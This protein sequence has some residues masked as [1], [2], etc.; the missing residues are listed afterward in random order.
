MVLLVLALVAAAGVTAYIVTRHHSASGV[1]TPANETPSTVQRAMLQ[2]GDLYA[3]QKS[4]LEPSQAR[5]VLG[6]DDAVTETDGG[7][8]CLPTLPHSRYGQYRHW[9]LQLVNGGIVGQAVVHIS[10]YATD[11]Q[12]QGAVDGRGS[13]AYLSCF[14][15]SQQTDLQAEAPGGVVQPAIISAQ[16]IEH[17]PER[18]SIALSTREDYTI[19]GRPC[20]YYDDERF[21]QVGDDVV[22]TSFQA[23]GAKFPPV[24]ERRLADT[25]ITR[26][27][28]VPEPSGATQGSTTTT[29]VPANQSPGPRPDVQAPIAIVGELRAY[30]PAHAAGHAWASS[31][32]SVIDDVG[33]IMVLVNSS[34]PAA[35]M[36]LC[37]VTAQE[38]YRDPTA[39][40]IAINVDEFDPKAT[41]A[42]PILA[43]RSGA[44]GT[45]HPGR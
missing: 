10:H 45:C 41:A 8:G 13:S 12:A 32:Q 11:A 38:M 37:N 15:R 23:C 16:T 36:D 34:D 9:G 31:Y 42:P 39:S 33:L 22:M 14:L 1:A 7:I 26:L 35:A 28:G 18:H 43:S 40:T 44:S 21:Q 29:T 19:G 27:T 4:G 24:E 5:W 6:E 30:L 25:I 3:L 20:T 17:G 2:T